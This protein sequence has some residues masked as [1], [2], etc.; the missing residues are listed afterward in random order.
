MDKPP[1]PDPNPDRKVVPIDPT[2]TKGVLQLHNELHKAE[3]AL[4]V[5]SR[6]GRI[7][8]A[9]FLYSRKVPGI[10]SAQ[11]QCR[12]GEETPRHMALFCN[13]EA[14]RRHQLTDPGGRAQ[15]FPQLVGSI[16]AVKGFVRLMMLSGRLS[17]FSPAKRL[18]FPSE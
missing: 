11:C 1:C 4:L 5:Q 10:T 15:S 14:N 2:P 8:L 9:R 3:S 16:K 17:Q 7:G 12:A 13:R 18:L 6:T